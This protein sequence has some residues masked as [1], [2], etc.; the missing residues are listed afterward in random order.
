MIAVGIQAMWF[1]ERCRLGLYGVRVSIRI[2]SI[3][4]MRRFLRLCS[5]RW[6]CR[7][8]MLGGWCG[9]RFQSWG[10]LRARLWFTT[11]RRSRAWGGFT[12]GGRAA[13]PRRLKRN[14]PFCCKPVQFF[15]EDSES[16]HQVLNVRQISPVLNLLS[17]FWKK[18][19][20]YCQISLG[21]C[22]IRFM[23][24]GVCWFKF[25][26]HPA[27]I[28]YRRTF[29]LISLLAALLPIRNFIFKPLLK[30]GSNEGANS[31]TCQELPQDF[32][33]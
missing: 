24:L 23:I 1:R 2:R 18:V 12:R 25:G 11:L 3:W 20:R 13:N 31:A 5:F 29:I 19:P 14:V 7:V 9:R 32:S 21:I 15:V 4:Y 10:S 22:E 28:T 16:R 30:G 26:N 8:G 33:P 17:F 27:T 6:V